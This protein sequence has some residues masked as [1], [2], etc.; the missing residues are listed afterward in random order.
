MKAICIELVD[1]Q[2][3]LALRDVDVPVPEPDQLLVRVACAGVNFA[4]LLRSTRHFGASLAS[5]AAVAGGE[6]A[7]EVV[8][9]GSAV[10]GI[11][12]GARVMGATN[13]AY[14][15]YCCVHHAHVMPV[16]DEMSWTDAAATTA[17]FMTAHNALAT[18]GELAPGE[19][20]LIHAASSG[21]GIAAVQ[22]AR[23]LGA[24][25]VIGTSRS[26]EK[27]ERLKA[28][29]MDVGINSEEEDFADTVLKVT[30]GHGADVIIDNIGGDT[31]PGDLRCAAIKARIVNV[32]RL[33][34]HL[35]G[36]IDLD[37]HA[38]KRIR[39]IGVTF[40]TRTLQ[41]HAEVVQQAANI[42]LPSMVDGT[43]KNIVDRVFPLEEAAA[44]QAYLKSGRHFGKVVLQVA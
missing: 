43:L 35:V 20:V 22:L 29:G 21:V 23:Q 33:S 38:R 8:T 31:L 32:G 26:P 18:V 11:T 7:G 17:T 34:G 5:K 39:Y 28:L 3:E 2:P 42:V 6:M 37:E 41:E 14:A 4:D 13:G 19:T 9:I 36:E 30:D 15:E 10:R 44:A 12:V 40:R 25:T 16:P 27:L 1:G 24:G